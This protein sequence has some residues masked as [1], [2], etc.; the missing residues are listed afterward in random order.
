MTTKSYDELTPA[1]IAESDQTL[2]AA[3]ERAQTGTPI[4]VAIYPTPGDTCCQRNCDQVADY[5]LCALYGTPDR[6]DLPLCANH[7]GPLA[8]EFASIYREEMGA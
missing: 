3:R 4:V 2:S 5:V 6:M 7:Y 8:A 1:E